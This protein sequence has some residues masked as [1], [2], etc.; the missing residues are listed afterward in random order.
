[1]RR[2]RPLLTPKFGVMAYLPSSED[3]RLDGTAWIRYKSYTVG[4]HQMPIR[5]MEALRHCENTSYWIYLMWADVAQPRYSVFSQAGY[6]SLSIHVTGPCRLVFEC[7]CSR[8]ARRP[9]NRAQRRGVLDPP[10]APR[11]RPLLT[12]AGPSNLVWR[13]PAAH[14]TRRASGAVA[15]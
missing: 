12:R 5:L 13:V 6:R 14:H 2:P 3:R 8:W 15:G 10:P 9:F 4:W 7:S 11:G 1:M